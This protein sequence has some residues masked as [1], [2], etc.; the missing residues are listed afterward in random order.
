MSNILRFIRFLW[1]FFRGILTSSPLVFY[2]I[3]NE[4]NI[5]FLFII[6]A[7][8]PF[9]FLLMFKDENINIELIKHEKILRKI[10]FISG[11]LFI[12]LVWFCLTM[13]LK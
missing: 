7:V 11:L 2:F 8:F 12:P 5:L 9:W 3:I 6:L 1:S 13:F 10:F 4:K